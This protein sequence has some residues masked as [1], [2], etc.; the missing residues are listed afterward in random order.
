[1]L[2]FSLSRPFPDVGA[3]SVSP[4]SLLSVWLF[5]C[6]ESWFVLFSYGCHGI[7]FWLCFF[8]LLVCDFG[9][10][11]CFVSV[12]VRFFAHADST[13]S[14]F[15]PYALCRFLSGFLLSSSYCMCMVFLSF[16]CLGVVFQFFCSFGFVSVFVESLAGWVLIDSFAFLVLFI[17][18]RFAYLIFARS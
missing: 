5:L 17:D 18:H 10:I 8:F 16:P 13:A 15:V 7:F 6:L 9:F 3:F 1:M 4:F 11:G 2:L 12:P 14:V